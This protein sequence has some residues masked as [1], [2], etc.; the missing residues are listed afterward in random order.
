[1]IDWPELRKEFSEISDK[2]ADASVPREKRV[3]L[4][5]RA[6]QLGRLLSLH[7]EMNKLDLEIRECKRGAELDD[8]LKALYEDELKDAKGRREELMHELE[9]I[10]SPPDVCDA[11]PAFLELRAGAGGQEASLFVADLFK[12]YSAYAQNKGWTVSV[13]SESPTEVGGFREIVMYVKGKGAFALFKHEAGVH[14]VQRVPTTEAA[15]RIHTS[16]ITVAVMPEASEVDISINP[17]DLRIDT[18]RASGAGGQHVNTTDSA[19][20]ITHVPTG[21]VVSCQEERSQ[22]K[23]REKALKVLRSRL[24]EAERE[25]LEQERSSARKEQVGTGERSEKIRTYNFPQNRVTDHRIG[26]T[27]KK[28]D[29]VMQGDLDDVIGPLMAADREKRTKNIDV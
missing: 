9:D 20:R 15:G 23:N 13:T 3:S 16:T 7:D 29:L 22:L 17:S 6:A 25:R 1:M 10:L 21:V 27:L 8:E 2:L 14:R 26:L 11:K 4:Q 18:F 5:R 24:F 19:V 12:M 28:L